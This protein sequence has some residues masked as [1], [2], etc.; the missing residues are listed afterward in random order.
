MKRKYA[1]GEE[2]C[3]HNDSGVTLVA[4]AM[5]QDWVILALKETIFHVNL[6]SC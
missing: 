5:G 3:Q 4:S 2:K 1:S 6:L